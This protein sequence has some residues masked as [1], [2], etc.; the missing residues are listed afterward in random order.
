MIIVKFIKKLY[1]IYKKEN[2][3]YHQ[4]IKNINN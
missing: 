4:L 1:K 2:I 3:F